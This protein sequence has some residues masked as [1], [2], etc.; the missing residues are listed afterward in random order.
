TVAFIYLSG[1]GLQLEGENYFVPVDAAIAR[2][3][4]VPTQ[5]VRLSDYTR[6]LNSL[7][8]KAT[9]LVVDAARQHPFAKA[10]TPLAGG[11]ALVDPA[12][13]ALIAFSAA[14]GT[15]APESKQGSYG[16]YAQALTEMLREGGLKLDE[17]FER[18]R[19]RV[20]ETTKGA[21]VPWSASNIE[22]PIVI[23]ERGADA[24]PQTASDEKAPSIA[25][26][27]IADLG[28][29]EA[30]IAAVNRDTIE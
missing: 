28:P 5:A 12:R 27:P 1:Y 8:I 2:D 26:E 25:D 11:L 7:N 23:F 3:L 6:P 9:V 30:Y 18:V 19:L 10:G 14:P 13:N 17:L 22:M 24:P 29:K 4:D 15:V 16:P 21:E 20:N